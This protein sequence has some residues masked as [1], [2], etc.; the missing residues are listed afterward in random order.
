M[1]GRDASK[2]EDKTAIIGGG[3]N[4][5]VQGKGVPFPEELGREITSPLVADAGAG[6]GAG[7]AVADADVAGAGAGA[8]HRHF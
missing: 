2:R 8:Q 5:P 4:S 1:A 3:K 7:A 6:T